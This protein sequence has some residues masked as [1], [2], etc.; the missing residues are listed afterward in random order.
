MIKSAKLVRLA[1]LGTALSSFLVVGAAAAS[2]GVGTTTDALRVRESAGTDA[3]TL[4]TAPAGASLIVLEDV[5]DGWYK[6]DYEGVQGFMSAEFLTVETTADA[7]IG[8]G[9]VNTEGSTL[10]VRAGAGTEFEQVAVLNNGDV[11]DI[12]GVENGWYK[13]TVS[14]TTGFVS[15]D[16]MITVKEAATSRSEADG[17]V[18]TSNLGS[19][20]AAYAQN[21]LGV[22]YV[23]GGNGPNSFD[24]SGFTKYVYNHFGYTLN[25]TASDQYSYN[26]TKVASMYD[27]QPGDLVFF[28]NTFRSS[29]YITHTGLYIGNG[30]FIHASTRNYNVRIDNL[31]TG[32]YAGKYAGGRH[33]I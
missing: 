30:Q 15:S 6:V 7:K 33:V 20:I 25:R 9:K 27:L 19:Q 28:T 17:A 11:V 31:F 24:C 23:M 1:V 8:Y 2:F 13:I 4:A 29:K 3:T 22:R 16:F 12:V 14:E 26:G 10:N 18:S 21:F 32:Y 5:V